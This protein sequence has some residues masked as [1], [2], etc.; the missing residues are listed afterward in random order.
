MT[1]SPQ[2]EVLWDNINYSLLSAHEIL[3]Y[4]YMFIVLFA[5]YGAHINIGFSSTNENTRP[6]VE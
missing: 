5:L 6:W 4:Y 1:V 2:F 3:G